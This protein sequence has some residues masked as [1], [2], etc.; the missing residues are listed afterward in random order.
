MLPW[1]HN[2]AIQLFESEK[3]EG[4]VVLLLTTGPLKMN[5]CLMTRQDK[6]KQAFKNKHWAGASTEM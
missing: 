1:I 2:S 5:K 3:E 6:N 4:V